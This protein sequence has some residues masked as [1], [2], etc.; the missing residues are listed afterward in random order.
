MNE[1]TNSVT[2]VS[3]SLLKTGLVTDYL[4]SAF[5]RAMEEDR[6]L[7][8]KHDLAK[9]TLAFINKP[10]KHLFQIHEI[11]KMSLMSFQEFMNKTWY[12]PSELV[13]RL[14][15]RWV[16]HDQ[17]NREEN[18]LN[19]LHNVNWSS[20]N[21]GFITAHLEEED[22]FY[23][24]NESLLTILKFL[25]K[26]NFVLHPRFT[27]VHHEMMNNNCQWPNNEFEQELDDQNSFLSI[28]INSSNREDQGVDETFSS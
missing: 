1:E 23:S 3:Q 19:L 12:F 14:V 11:E 24:I 15:T 6:Q 18:F 27:K 13:L 22:P 8:S 10:F 17:N 7:F 5:T 26:L 2:C 4:C 20:L 9:Q 28:A 16:S 25:D 21:P